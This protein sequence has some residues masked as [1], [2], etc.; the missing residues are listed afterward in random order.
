MEKK[1]RN[2]VK[3][4]H[5]GSY[6][7]GGSEQKKSAHSR[8][9]SHHKMSTVEKHRN[10]VLRGVSEW[11]SRLAKKVM[12]AKDNSNNALASANCQELRHRRFHSFT[13]SKEIK[14]HKTKKI[15]CC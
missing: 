6:K 14:K 13:I 12:R 3:C 4:L 8:T 9:Q 11:R 10:G 2:Q 5:T 15:T 1:R 7:N